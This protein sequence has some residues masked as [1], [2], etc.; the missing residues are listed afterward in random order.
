MPVPDTAGFRAAQDW[1]REQVGEDIPFHVPTAKVYP[2]GTQ[3]DPE[4]GEPYDP[5]IEQESGGEWTDV[6]KK[7]HVVFRPIHVNLEDPVGGQHQGGGLRRATSLVLDLALTDFEEVEAATEAT[8]N[9]VRY[10]ITEFE[11]DG[12]LG[13]DRVLAFAEAK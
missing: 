8:V 2:A 7:V 11:K 12:I 9:D 1:F 13:P 5:T 3:L 10:K 4:T 6:T